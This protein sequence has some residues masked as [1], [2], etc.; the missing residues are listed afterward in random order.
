MKYILIAGI[1]LLVILIICYFIKRRNAIRKVRCKCL[2]EKLCHVNNILEPF[3]F[4]FE[5]K[6][7]IVISKNDA[8]QRD[9]GYTDFYDIKA[10]FLSM[11]MN[12]EPIFFDY[13]GK[14]FRLEL[15]KGQYG[16]TTGG[17]MGLYVR[18]ENSDM[19]KNFYRCALDSER[20]NMGFAL[21]K[22][23]YLFSR[24][25]KSWWLTGFDVGRFSRPKEL[26]MQAYVELENEYM[27]QSF[28]NGLLN[29]GYSPNKIEV[30]GNCVY[31]SFCEPYNYKLNHCM[32]F[33]KFVAQIFNRINCSLY[34]FFTRPFN[35]S[36][37]KIAFIT[38]MFP[39]LYKLIIK[40]CLP[41]RKHKK[42]RRR[43]KR[44]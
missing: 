36:L 25:D 20:L 7:G 42:C 5:L 29:A 39:H 35:K 27:C 26:M 28:V 16:I 44:N 32:K 18:E 6:D 15:W 3:G 23:C 41:K 43:K 34:M 2:S 12:A 21:Y 40:I 22:K 4:E 9:L 37:D 10:P 38:Y 19:P 30:C 31:F 1:I 17:E 11:V 14:H 33:V 24:C 8:W 13:D